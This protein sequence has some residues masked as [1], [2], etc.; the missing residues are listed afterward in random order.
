[1]TRGEIAR[2][3]LEALNEDATD[4]T[5][6]TR[7]EIN[8]V[9]TEAGEVLAEEI[10]QIKRTAEIPFRAGATF[11]YTQSIAKDI[12][13]PYRLWHATQSWRLAPCTIMDL[14]RRHE[15]WITVSGDPR[16]W[17]PVDWRLFG[18][19]PSPAQPGGVLRVDYL[20]WARELID[21]EDTSEFNESD[22]DALV[23]YGV[24]FG[25]LKQWDLPRAIAV[26]AQFVEHIP[27]A[28]WRKGELKATDFQRA[29]DPARDGGVDRLFRA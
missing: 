27:G 7:D 2:R 20:A 1:M 12:L 5:F 8:G 9:I 21:D 29:A 10:G 24:Y 4:P 25:L 11:Y 22:H 28:L 19:W 13:A 26:F 23:L 16:Y 18:V 6:W 17:F 3:I 14:D 15:T